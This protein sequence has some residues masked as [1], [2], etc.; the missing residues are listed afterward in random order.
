[1]L[2]LRPFQWKRPTTM[3]EAVSLLSASKGR[4]YIYSGGTDLMP[5]MKLAQIDAEVVISLAGIP[6]L[7]RIVKKD[8]AIL[9]G[10]RTCL[11]D[12]VDSEIVNKHI[13]VL[14]FA[15]SRIGSQQI[16]NSGTLGGN[17]CLETRCRYI[18]QSEL[19]RQALGGCLKSHGKECHVVPGGS[20]CVAAMSADSVPALIVLDA[21]V[22][23]IGPTGARICPISAFYKADGTAHLNLL[24]GEIVHQIE[25]PV[26]SKNNLYAYRK[27]AVRKSIDFPLV[28]IGIRIERMEH[29]FHGG[30]IAVGVLGPV[31]KLLS[32]DRYKGKVL[33][34]DVCSE[35]ADM[36]KMKCKTLPNVPYNVDYRR[37]RLGVEVKRGLLSML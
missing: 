31:P 4:A 26:P 30:A 6:N 8:G 28:S 15:V 2:R 24:D 27:W 20:K 7:N 10:A 16:R 29:L 9:I 13:P 3:V 35:I 17:V 22:H 21:K 32:L 12:I 34:A 37:L 14:A 33:N 5:N 23:L 19:F 11:Q 25:I 18:N 1:M 36:V